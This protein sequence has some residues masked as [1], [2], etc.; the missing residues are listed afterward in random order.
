[1]GSVAAVDN[2]SKKIGGE[3]HQAKPIYP[4]SGQLSPTEQLMTTSDDKKLIDSIRAW[5]TIIWGS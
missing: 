4:V 2:V 3:T 1:M 5:A